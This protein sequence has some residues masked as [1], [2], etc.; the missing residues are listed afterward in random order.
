MHLFEQMVEG[1]DVVHREG[2]M[3]RDIKPENVFLRKGGFTH[4]SLLAKLGDFGIGR[5]ATETDAVASKYS[6]GVGTDAYKAPELH[7]FERY[8]QSNDVWALG[9]ILYEMLTG[10]HPF[11]TIDN[12][13]N[14]PME[15][16]PAWVSTHLRELLEN[17]LDK[18]PLKRKT[19]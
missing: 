18:D 11:R 13:I 7:K 5:E 4:L 9:V 3:H 12:V 15:P 10:A 14:K 19:T 6:M 1:L 17:L 16:L 2:Q 8:G